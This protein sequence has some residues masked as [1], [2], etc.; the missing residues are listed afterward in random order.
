MQHVRPFI[1]AY[2]WILML[3]NSGIIRKTI[4][5]MLGIT[6]PS[7]YGF[8]GILL[9]LSLQLFPLV[10]LYVSGA[11]KNIDNSLWKP[12]RAWAARAS[13]VF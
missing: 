13:S 1:G 7:I 6:L 12:P 3:G 10:F 8:N 5:S 9:V 11:M 4:K 2:S